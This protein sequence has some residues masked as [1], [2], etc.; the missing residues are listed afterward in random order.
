M[1]DL[2]PLAAGYVRLAVRLPPGKPL[3]PGNLAKLT[4][5]AAEHVGPISIGDEEAFIDVTAAEGRAARYNLTRLGPAVLAERRWQWLRIAV[6]RNHGMNM[7]QLRRILQNAGAHPVGKIIINNTH[8]LVG[9]AD[10][11]LP[12][13][14]T[15]LESTRINGFG[16][17]PTSLPFGSGP[18]SPAFAPRG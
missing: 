18:G 8:T 3:T 9:L 4:G 13:V 1:T 15:K 11:L 10:D 17:K 5:L 16:A 14:L 7:G 12:A 2:P 6:G